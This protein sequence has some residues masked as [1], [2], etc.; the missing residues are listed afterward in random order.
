[1]EE[2]QRKKQKGK[3]QVREIFPTFSVSIED[4]HSQHKTKVYS[5]V[6][7]NIENLWILRMQCTDKTEKR[8]RADEYFFFLQMRV[9]SERS[10]LLHEI[11]LSVAIFFV[12]W[13]LPFCFFPSVWRFKSINSIFPLTKSEFLFRN[14]FNNS[15][16]IQTD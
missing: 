15:S 4:S 16:K 10:W 9:T 3:Y 12:L 13:F 14:P 6:N 11:F 5:K 8:A 2:L 7:S 1:M